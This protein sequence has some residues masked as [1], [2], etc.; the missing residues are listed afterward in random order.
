MSK[1]EIEPNEALL[2][3]W[4]DLKYYDS[5]FGTARAEKCKVGFYKYP[6]IREGL[7]KLAQWLEELSF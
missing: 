7:N 1:E 5:V 4:E 3:I 6:K 2:R